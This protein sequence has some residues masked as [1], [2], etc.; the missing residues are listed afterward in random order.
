MEQNKFFRKKTI[1][2]RKYQIQLL[3]ALKAVGMAK[4]L[5]KV[6]LPA[7]GG[8]IDGMRDDGFNGVPKT[9]T[10]LALVI[11]TQLDGLDLEDIIQSLLEGCSCDGTDVVDLDSHFQGEL[12]ELVG[13]LEFALKENFS[14]FFTGNDL[15]APLM[16][17]MEGMGV[18]TSSLSSEL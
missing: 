8:T 2:G 13:V 17:M 9:F 4:T 10:D 1:N 6:V 14:S 5:S 16:K 3:P 7:L 15:I 11:C 18:S 12:G